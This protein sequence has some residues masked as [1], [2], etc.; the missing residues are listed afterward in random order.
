MEKRHKPVLLNEVLEFLRVEKEEKYLDATVGGGGHS[1]AIL[2]AGGIVLGIDQDPEAV[3]YAR[4]RL[5]QICPAPKREKQTFRGPSSVFSWK[6][7][8]GNFAFLK[9][10]T[11]KHRFENIAGVLF[12]LGMA[13]FQLASA[14]RGFS[15]QVDGPLDM[16]LDPNLKVTAADLVN[17]LSEGELNELFKKMADEQLAGPIAHALVRARHLKPITRTSQLAD[18]VAEVYRKRRRFK[19]I[20]PATKVFQALRIAVNSE[21]ENLKKGLPAAIKVLKPGGRIVIISFHSGE[22]RLVKNFFREQAKKDKLKILTKKPIRPT[23]V[24]IRANPLSRSARLRGG[25]KI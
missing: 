21:F 25:E 5:N 1:E 9:A 13:S 3:F 8:Q 20:H 12:D 14:H 7:V 18:L 17:V 2:K 19:K 4:K 24:E 10:I 6:I 15:F 23:L 16:R 11:K 22:D